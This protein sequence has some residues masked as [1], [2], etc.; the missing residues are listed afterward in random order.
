MHLNCQCVANG[1]WS[2]LSLWLPSFLSL[3]HYSIIHLTVTNFP[4]SSFIANW[5]TVLQLWS[6]FNWIVILLHWKLEKRVH[7]LSLHHENSLPG[8]GLSKVHLWNWLCMSEGSRLPCQKWI[9]FCIYLCHYSLVWDLKLSALAL[10][11]F[12]MR[13]NCSSG[14]GWAAK[15][16]P[17]WSAQFSRESMQSGNASSGFFRHFPLKFPAWI[18]PH[19]IMFWLTWDFFPQKYVLYIYFILSFTSYWMP[20][21]EPEI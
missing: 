3:G 9:W 18:F 2:Q 5:I 1:S 16:W 20:D 7:F 17:K 8:K 12:L 14:L 21:V 19:E 4:C 11:G 6:Y 15:M 13:I 10:E